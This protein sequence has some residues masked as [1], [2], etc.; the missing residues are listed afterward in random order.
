MKSCETGIAAFQSH[1]VNATQVCAKT[2]KL[3]GKVKPVSASAIAN[4]QEPEGLLS[5]GDQ[6]LDMLTGQQFRSSIEE[7]C[8]ILSGLTVI[9]CACPTAVLVLGNSTLA[10]DL[11]TLLGLNRTPFFTDAVISDKF[12]KL[13]TCQ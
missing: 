2:V 9:A 8:A 12:C 4:A 10:A 5:T 6:A 11:F 1:T 13:R 3:K 7:C